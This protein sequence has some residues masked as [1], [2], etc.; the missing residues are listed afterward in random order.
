MVVTSAEILL[1]DGS[2]GHNNKAFFTICL[3]AIWIASCRLAKNTGHVH[4][5]SMKPLRACSVCGGGNFIWA[6]YCQWCGEPQK[7][8]ASLEHGFDLVHPVHPQLRSDIEDSVT[9]IYDQELHVS[10]EPGYRTGWSVY[11]FPDA[12]SSVAQAPVL[13]RAL[14][15]AEPRRSRNGDAL[16]SC[17]LVLDD[18]LAIKNCVIRR[19]QGSSEISLIL[20]GLEQERRHDQCGNRNLKRARVCAACGQPLAERQRSEKVLYDPVVEFVSAEH[21]LLIEQALAQ[22]LNELFKV[23]TEGVFDC[24]F[25]RGRLAGYHRVSE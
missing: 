9:K 2:K 12:G 25:R 16:L 4:M 24:Q 19:P 1:L 11:S 23:Q 10:Q 18:E 17:K 14:L 15:R 7:P 8:A 13:T 21:Q 22:A 5:P 20:P 6:K 3:G